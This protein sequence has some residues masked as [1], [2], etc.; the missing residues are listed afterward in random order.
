[1]SNQPIARKTLSE[2]VTAEIRK[3]IIDH[4]LKTGD[5]LPTEQQF[6][7]LFG[8]SRISIREATKALSFLGIIRAATRRGLT[9]GEVDMHR[10]AEFLGFHFALSNYPREQLLKARIVI[11]TGALPEAMERIAARPELYAELVSINDGLKSVQDPEEFVRRDLAFHRALL[12][13]SGIE[14]L[15]AF[16]S[17]LEI[18]FKRFKDQ[19]SVQRNWPT[20]IAAHREIIE[21]LKNRDLK[22]ASDLLGQHL[23][24]FQDP[25]ATQKG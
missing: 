17:V 24:H 25:K 12:E 2:T 13:A 22:K 5:R 20:G 8:V 1:M 23:T 14:P 21:A 9:V 15:V 11:E 4:D 6:A 10:V 19:I 16:S 7:E 3:Y 18:F